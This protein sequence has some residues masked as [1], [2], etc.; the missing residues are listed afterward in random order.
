MIQDPLKEIREHIENKFKD[1]S[2]KDIVNQIDLCIRLLDRASGLIAVVHSE[3][4]AINDQN[5]Q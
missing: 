4:K 2:V 1:D 3:L 5:R